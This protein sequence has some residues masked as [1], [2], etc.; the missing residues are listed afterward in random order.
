MEYRNDESFAGAPDSYVD[1][2]LIDK[3]LPRNDATIA[4]ARAAWAVAK[5]VPADLH[6]FRVNYVFRPF[7]GAVPQDRVANVVAESG[8][9]AA[10][11]MNSFEGYE[12]MS[13]STV[14]QDVFMA[15]P[16]KEI[17][18]HRKTPSHPG[19]HPATPGDLAARGFTPQQIAGMKGR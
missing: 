19:T 17:V 1:Q 11:F 5:H 2:Y 16:A 13:V 14:A 15:P 18:S 6:V 3:K 7:K 8:P 12:V 4:D 9:H 10:A